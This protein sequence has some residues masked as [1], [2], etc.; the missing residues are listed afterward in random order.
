MISLQI[1]DSVRLVKCTTA[2]TPS[3]LDDVD[4]ALNPYIGCNHGCLYCYSPDI[5][6]CPRQD[7]WGIWVDAKVNISRMLRKEVAELRG[8]TIGLAT[9]TDPYQPVEE[10]L[11]L[12]RACLEILSNS[13]I[14]LMLMT[15]SPLVLR[16][17][18]LLQ[19][20]KDV[21]ICVTITTPDQTI[22]SLL[23]P[24]APSLNSRFKILKKASE[25]AL[26][27]T[28]MI[29]PLLVSSENPR[30]EIIELIDRIAQTGC[31]SISFDR[32]RLRASAIRRIDRMHSQLI[33]HSN[34]FNLKTVVDRS[35]RV[36][37]TD[38]LKSIAVKKHHPSMSI[39]I[40]RN[41]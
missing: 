39:E 1:D 15:K 10:K 28:A 34:A 29:S 7:D 40:S 23:E 9:V 21:E 5:L 12:S 33:S 25:V 22:S 4:Y 38:L 30:Q 31:K 37:I 24:G 35:S 6:R 13:D 20:M 16:D 14:S 18:D 2:I 26:K 27:T 11:K 8:V 19:K 32:L 41:V 3:G 36:S 17:F